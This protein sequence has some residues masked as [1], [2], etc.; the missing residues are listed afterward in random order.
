MKRTFSKIALPNT[1]KPV[2]NNTLFGRCFPKSYTIL[3]KPFDSKD[4]QHKTT[5]LIKLKIIEAYSVTA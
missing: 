1:H 4:A 5:D 3:S 2:R